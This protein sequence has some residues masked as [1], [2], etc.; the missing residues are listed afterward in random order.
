M[1][2]SRYCRVLSVHFN[3]NI[4]GNTWSLLDRCAMKGTRQENPESL[5][6]RHC[7]VMFAKQLNEDDGCANKNTEDEVNEE[8]VGS[9]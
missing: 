6:K 2:S 8:L 1:H 7:C 5:S 3:S 4:L 9:K